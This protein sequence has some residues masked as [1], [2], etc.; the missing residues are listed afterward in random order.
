MKTLRSWILLVL[1]FT[2]H[3]NST[4]PA[5]FSNFMWENE[6]ITPSNERG[7]Q[8][9]GVLPRT[10]T[11]SVQKLKNHLTSRGFHEI[12]SIEGKRDGKKHLL[13][14]WKKGTSQIMLMVVQLDTDRTLVTWGDATE[15]IQR[16]QP[17]EQQSNSN[18][19]TT[20]KEQYE[21]LK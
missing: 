16:R 9:R 3:A 17:S 18:N 21:K 8:Q 12:H 6:A 2:Y 7:W 19:G 5:L 11:S 4:E 1:L 14:L 10:F 15:D 20:K 13:G